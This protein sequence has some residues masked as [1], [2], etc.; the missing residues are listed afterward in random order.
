LG[1][2]QEARHLRRGRA[3]CPLIPAH[4]T[5]D[6]R[7]GGAYQNLFWSVSA[8]NL[9]NVMYYDYAVASSSTY[10]RYNAY[11]LAGRT[12]MVKAGATF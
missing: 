11:P 12:F 4:T 2:L 7:L 5:V 8:Q 9:F 3:L 1:H 6:L 10:G